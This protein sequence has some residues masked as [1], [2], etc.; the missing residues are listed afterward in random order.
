MVS[1]RDDRSWTSLT[2]CAVRRAGAARAGDASAAEAPAPASARAA[3]A[4]LTAQPVTLVHDLS[5]RVLATYAVF[6]AVVLA[7]GGFALG[8]RSRRFGGSA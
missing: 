6:F 8:R 1:T 3:P 4:R 5:S 2:G 7:G